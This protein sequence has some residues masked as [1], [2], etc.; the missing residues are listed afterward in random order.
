MNKIATIL[1]VLSLVLIAVLFFMFFNHTEQLKRISL[2]EEKKTGSFFKIAYFDI[3]SLEVH[4][5]YFKDELDSVKAQENAMNAEL[6]GMEKK[7]QKRIS[8]L[9][10]KGSAMTPSETEQANQEFAAMQ[11][12]Y[13]NRKQT[14]Q[15]ELYKNDEEVKSRIKTKIEDFLK[16]YNKT[17]NFSYIFM[18][19]ANSF[20]YYRDTVF[21]IT[22][23]LVDGLNATYKK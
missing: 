19:E 10:Q 7:Y 2:N 17:K 4:Y 18:Y 12:N 1:G 8:E 20:I 6:S 11:Q 9:Q 16:E 5:N 15:E 13:Q 3:D 22:Q 21:N 14:L 23:D